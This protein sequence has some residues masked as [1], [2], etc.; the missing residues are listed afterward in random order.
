MRFLKIVEELTKLS[1]I[2]EELDIRQV[3]NVD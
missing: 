2:E 3:D 1:L